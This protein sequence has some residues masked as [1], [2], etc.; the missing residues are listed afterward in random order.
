M[1][2]PEPPFIEVTPD[3]DPVEIAVREFNGTSTSRKTWRK[4]LH[5]LYD[6]FGDID[7]AQT[8]FCQCI[9]TAK[10]EIVHDAIPDETP[11]RGRFAAQCHIHAKHFTNVIKPFVPKG[12][13]K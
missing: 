1:N 2:T 11:R 3:D 5:A 13:P 9:V 4:Y 6:R 7:R 12:E 10:S 8:F